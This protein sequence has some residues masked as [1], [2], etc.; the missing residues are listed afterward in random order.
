MKHDLQ[1]GSTS[2]EGVSTLRTVTDDL[3]DAALRKRPATAY[4]LRFD[5]RLTTEQ[6]EALL[7]ATGD[8]ANMDKPKG[9]LTNRRTGSP[10]DRYAG[11]L[12]THSAYLDGFSYSDRSDDLERVTNQT[13]HNKLNQCQTHRND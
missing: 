9:I 12:G 6:N 8:V 2:Q 1:F 7:R 11:D 4:P 10:R 13:K 3:V 5:Q